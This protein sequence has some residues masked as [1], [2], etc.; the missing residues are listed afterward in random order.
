MRVLLRLGVAL[1]AVA[2]WLALDDA[3]A[4]ATLTL[5]QFGPGVTAGGGFQGFVQPTVT[6]GRSYVAPADGTIT[7]WSVEAGSD[8]GQIKLK[9]YRKIG[10]PATFQVVT[11]DISRPITPNILNIFFVTLPGIQAGDVIG[12]F[13]TGGAD[14]LFAVTG[15]TYLRGSGDLA[16]GQSDS[17]SSLSGFRVNTEVTFEPSHQFSLG[18]VRRNKKRGT[19]ILTAAFPGPGYVILH[20]KGLK[21]RNTV[22]PIAAKGDVGLPIG[23]VGRTR[24]TLLHTGKATLKIALVY[25][26]SAGTQGSLSTKVRLRKAL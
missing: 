10:D 7:S 25:Q 20:G 6:S 22:L 18:G 26:P 17:F 8:G 9:V 12:N 11:Q 14:T 3:T 16:T 21:V 1:C 23:A 19:A 2:L 15:E 4:L 5:G 13:E 24:R